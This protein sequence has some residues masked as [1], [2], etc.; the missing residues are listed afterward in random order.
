VK[1]TLLLYNIP[2]KKKALLSV[3]AM[4]LGLKSVSV[5]AEAFSLPLGVILG[6]DAP[7]GLPAPS[8]EPFEGE[9]MVMC[10]LS[11]GELDRFLSEL[12]RVRVNI[13]LKA[14]LTDTNRAWSAPQLFAELSAER[15]AIAAGRKAHGE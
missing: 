6:G 2:Q 5:P 10:G 11:D 12:R 15:E 14:I 3:P 13:P 9:M 8:E 7:A 1:P 4:C